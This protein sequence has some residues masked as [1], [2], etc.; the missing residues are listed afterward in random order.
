MTV[1]G[2]FNFS[3]FLRLL[4]EFL[5]FNSKHGNFICWPNNKIVDLVCRAYTHR[6][7]RAHESMSAASSWFTGFRLLVRHTVV[8]SD[9]AFAATATSTYMCGQC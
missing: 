2:N 8:K 1:V 6:R 7:A 9:G 5:N 3:Y 4:W